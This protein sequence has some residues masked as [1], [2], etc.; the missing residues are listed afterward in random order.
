MHIAVVGL[1]YVGLVTAT[2]LAR[3]GQ[4]V[5]GLEA[6]RDK[7]AALADGRTPFYEPGLDGELAAQRESGR[8]R[9]TA[10]PA[11]ALRDADAVLICVGTPSA[12]D[13]TAD[14]G[15]VNAVADAIGAHLGRRA[16][17]AL[18]STVPVGTTRGVERRLN[19]ALAAR[20]GSGPVPVIANPEFLRTGRALDDFLRPSRVVLGRTEL[21]SDADVDLLA[22]LYRPLAAPI[23]VFDA[24]SA[25]LV[26]NAAN[27]YLA[28]RIS[29]VNELAQL[30]EASSASIEAVIA[31]IAPDPRIGGEYLRPGLG[32]GGSCLPKDVRSLIA[33]GDERSLP[34][35]LAR[36]V[37]QVNADQPVGV[38]DRL[39]TALGGLDGRRIALLGLAF[40][41]DTD[42]IRDSPALTLATALRER[43]AV[44]VGCDPQ[45]GSRVAA[46]MPWIELA[47][48]PLEAVRGADAAVLATEW[49]A[50]VTLDPVAIR[51]AMR[52]DVLFDARNALDPGRVT[53]AGLRYL[54]VG[55]SGSVPAVAAAVSDA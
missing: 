1:G 4:D 39:A 46:T 28:L 38:A 37:D 7:L 25:E 16:V 27:A 21:A 26:K 33:Q 30:C 2:C 17:V 44:V 31:G 35:G 19:D 45:A 47:R 8:L 5:V 53:A 24:E 14:L 43:G 22:A 11:E 52:G 23:L 41:P 12:A 13:G 9:F 15:A 40:K 54:A 6:D 29:F 42:D 10:D 20:D 51:A 49:P 55:R 34:M 50:Y 48:S 18:R 32:Y 36:A 3:L